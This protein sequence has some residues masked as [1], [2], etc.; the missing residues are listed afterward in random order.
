MMG[1]EGEK[2]FNFEQHSSGVFSQGCN[3]TSNMVLTF[4]EYHVPPSRDAAS[5]CVCVSEIPIINS[6]FSA[7]LIEKFPG[8]V[9]ERDLVKHSS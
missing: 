5:V 6:K 8:E 7:N 3:M 9:I 2:G 4:S 1:R